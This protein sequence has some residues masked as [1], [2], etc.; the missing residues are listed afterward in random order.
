MTGTESGVS[1]PPETACPASMGRAA[2][3]HMKRGYC[4]SE[5]VVLSATEALLPGADIDVEAIAGGLCG[6]MGNRKGPC[7]IFTGGATAIGLVTTGLGLPRGRG[8]VHQ[9]ST[10]YQRRL[11]QH[12]G[13]HICEAL[14][15]QMGWRNWNRRRC[16]RLTGDGARI[17]G[18]V[19]LEVVQAK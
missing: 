13:G 19:I 1:L 8:V 6:G 9:L 18:E 5:A 14:L 15:A 4:C 11:E 7:G 16:R 2:M 10:E 3:R 17:L 12:A